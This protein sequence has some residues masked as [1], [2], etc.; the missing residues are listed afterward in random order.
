M[1]EYLQ[2]KYDINAKFLFHPFFPYPA[3]SYNDVNTEGKNK[4]S[5]IEMCY[6]RKDFRD[7]IEDM[8]EQNQKH[9]SKGQGKANSVSICRIDYGKNVD[10]VMR[11][12]ELLRK[13]KYNGPFEDVGIK[14]YGPYNP[15]YVNDKLGGLNSFKRY[16]YGIFKKSLNAISSILNKA[17][18]VID[19]SV[20]QHDGGGTQYTFLE[21][22]HHDAVLIINRKWLDNI[23]EKYCDFRDGYNC[24]AVSDEYELA[25]II[26]DNRK[27]YD[28]NER[29]RRNAKRIMERHLT[30]DWSSV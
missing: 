24:Y 13:K 12:N 29:I 9:G 20:I 27:D 26:L 21:A 5:Y 6:S 18:F 4:N 30:V 7:I 2:H 3:T 19:L 1:Q 17:K 15:R 28:K 10:I 25:Q 11:A 16:Y 23:D 14:M 8:T 22:I